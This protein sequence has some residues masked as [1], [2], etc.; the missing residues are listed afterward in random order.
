VPTLGDVKQYAADIAYQISDDSADRLI[1]Y[2]TRQAL[3]RLWAA[4]DWSYYAAQATIT[5]DPEETGTDLDVT[6]GS[7]AFVRGSTWTAKYAAASQAWDLLVDGTDQV[8]RIDTIVTVTATLVSGQVWRDDTDTGLDY[9]LRRVR[10]SVPDDFSK[11]L[12]R[13]QEVDSRIVLPYLHPARF[14]QWK[15]DASQRSGLPEAYTLRGGQYIEFYPAPG[16]DR[17][18]INLT[19]IRR[20]TLPTSATLDATDIDWPDEYDG[21]FR[22]TVELEAARIQG[23]QAQVGYPIALNEFASML[24]EMKRLDAQL[25]WAPS[26]MTLGWAGTG[27]AWSPIGPHSGRDGSV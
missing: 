25:G 7:G 2:W 3:E 23:E 8:F 20:P 1:L 19:Y 10:Y 26:N 24:T 27:R 17:L 15:A 9:T 14:D 21:L 4:Y 18:A 16:A 11:K 22:K 6:E 12:L 13:V 5:E